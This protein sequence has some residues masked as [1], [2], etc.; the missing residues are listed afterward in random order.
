MV[1]FMEINI[2]EIWSKKALK[3]GYGQVQL[4]KEIPKAIPSLSNVSKNIN[5][6]F[7]PI[8]YSQLNKYGYCI[9]STRRAGKEEYESSYKICPI[10][11]TISDVEKKILQRQKII[12]NPSFI[13]IYMKKLSG[14]SFAFILQK[15]RFGKE[16]NIFYRVFEVVL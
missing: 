12:N 9:V 15:E 13:K 6:G 2:N 7:I 5:S 1:L 10:N 4:Y 8:S 16:E 11:I 3:N 14:T